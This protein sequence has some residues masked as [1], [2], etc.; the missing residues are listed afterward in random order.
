MRPLSTLLLLGVVVAGFSATQAAAHEPSAQPAI[1]P[2]QPPRPLLWKVSDAD[3]SLY[4]LG[5]FHLLKA[6]DY[7]LS[8]DIDAA[9]ADAER[10][11]FEIDP[12]EMNSPATAQAMLA[13]AAYSDD[14]TLSTVLPAD[15]RAGLEKMLAKGGGSMTQL[16]GLEPWFVNLSMVLGA[17]Q[18]LGFRIEQGL[19]RHLMERAAK[20]GKPVAGLETVAS[21]FAALDGVPHSEQVA[22]LQEFVAD[23]G[24][25]NAELLD[26]HRLWREGDAKGLGDRM[27]ADMRERTPQMYRRIN[28][29]RNTAW[30]A[31]LQQQLRAPG[32]DDTLVVV[33]SLHL[34]GSDGLVDRLRTAG[35]RVERIC[36][37]C[38]SVR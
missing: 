27:L 26:L 4:L 19:D 7:P 24:K 30:M 12:A 3:N 11:L 25:A 8:R 10:L 28:V 23:P 1:A 36:S 38:K 34:L 9:F 5:S 21:Q 18:S 37:G 16:D 2:A 15:T 32:T 17:A 33:G 35:Y 22:G 20:A 6:Q 29:E 13:A 14:K 31:R